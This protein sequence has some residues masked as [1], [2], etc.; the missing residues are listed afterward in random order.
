VNVVRV[1]FQDFN[2]ATGKLFKRVSPAVD[3]LVGCQWQLTLKNKLNTQ[4]LSLYVKCHVS[5]PIPFGHAW[6]VRDQGMKF[7]FINQFNRSKSIW[8]S[9]HKY[10]EVDNKPWRPNKTRYGFGFV[11]KLSA[12]LDPQGGFIVNNC[13]LMEIRIPTLVSVEIVPE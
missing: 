3:C 2:S 5:K 4:N 9:W 11:M 8:K 6:R 10:G 1:P 12:L 13:L 7:G